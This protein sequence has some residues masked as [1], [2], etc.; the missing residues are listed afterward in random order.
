LYLYQYI[1]TLRTIVTTNDIAYSFSLN[2]MVAVAH[3]LIGHVTV[4]ECIVKHFFY[5]L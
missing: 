4:D 1:T 3:S 5:T 2:T